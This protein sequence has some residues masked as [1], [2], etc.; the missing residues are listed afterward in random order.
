[1]IIYQV[2]LSAQGSEI[3]LLCERREGVR[4]LSWKK[5]NNKE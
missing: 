3:A 4:Q 5:N 1:M 2:E